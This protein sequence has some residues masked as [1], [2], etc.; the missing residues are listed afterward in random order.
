MKIDCTIKDEKKKINE[1]C[2]LF[3]VSSYP[4]LVLVDGDS[5]YDYK[6]KRELKNL[7]K[8][9]ENYNLEE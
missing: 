6:G 7:K 8:Y 9:T 3:N 2:K 5:I 1:A 4:T